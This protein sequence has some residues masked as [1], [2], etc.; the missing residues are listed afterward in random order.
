MNTFK[1]P[2]ANILIVDDRRENIHLLSHILREQGYRVRQAITAELA[3]STIRE[4]LPDLILLDVMLPDMNGYDLCKQLKADERTCEIPVLFMSVLDDT[5][6]KLKAF[7]VGGADY[8]SK[9]FEEQ[10]VLAHVKTHLALRHTQKQLE[11]KIVELKQ[12]KNA[13]RE[14]EK[15]YRDLVETINDAIYQT[16]ADGIIEYISPAITVMFGYDPKAMVGQCFTQFLYDDDIGMYKEYFDIARSGFSGTIEMQ[17]ITSSLDIKWIRFS[18]HSI[19]AKGRFIGTRG[20]ITDITKRKQVEEMLRKSEERLSSFMDSA[21]DGFILFDSELNYIKINSA[22]LEMT[23]LDREDVIG[24]NI[25]DIVPNLKE[26]GRYDKYKNVIETGEPFFISNLMPHP[27]FGL[28]H[29]EIKAFKISGGLGYIFTDITE[30]K[31]AEEA[32]RESEQRLRS[33]GDNL[34]SVQ[35]YQLMV[36]PDGTIRFTYVS[37]AVEK[38][39]ECTAE[40]VIADASLLYDRVVEEDR[41]GMRLASEKS[42]R[43]MDV[44]DQE[45]RIRRKSGEIRWHRMTSRPR[46]TTGNVILF[47]GIDMDIT[48]RKKTEIAVLEQKESYERLTDNADEAL[49]RVK[50]DGGE[51]IF[52]NPATERIFGYSLKEW[53]A[54]KAHAFKIIHPDFMEKQQRVIEKINTTK[55]PFKDVELGWIAKD[56]RTIFMEHTIIPVLDKEG[57]IIYFEALGRDITERKQAKQVLIES[58]VKHRTLFE[59]MSQ[60]VVYQ[61]ADGHIISANSSAENILG[62]SLEQMTGRTSLDPRWRAIHEDGSEFPGKTHPGHVAMRTGKSVHNEIMGVFHPK[63]NRYKWISIDA[64]PQF[65]KGN[66]KPYQVYAT[67]TDITER[68]QAEE[69][70]CKLNKELEQKV[71][72]RTHDLGQRVK[73]LN[74]LYSISK[75]VETPDASLEE[76]LQGTVNLISPF[77]QYSDITCAR[78]IIEG[79]MF[80]TDNFKE[81]IW[82][83]A[84]DILDKGE[85]IGSLDV[86]YLEERQVSDEGPFLKEERNMIDAITE[87][88][89][90]VVER[91]YAEEALLKSEKRLR[92]MIENS[93]LPM[94]ITDANQ[95]MEYFNDKFTELFG[96]TLNDVSTA[97]QWWQI[98]YPDENYRRSVQKSWMDAIEYAIAHDEDIEMQEWDLTIKDR[99]K[100]RCEFY[101]VPFEEFSLIIMNDITENI[102][103]QTELKEAKK[104][105]ETANKAKSAFLANMSHELRTPLNA[106]LGFAQLML[107]DSDLL[108]SQRKNME[109]VNRSGEHLL[110]LINDILDMSK[111]EAGRSILR[112]R[113]FDL[114]QTLTNIEEM[115]RVRAD[116]ANL[117]F[118]VFRD[119]GV[120][121]YIQGDDRKLRQV[122]INLLNNAIKF[123]EKG[124]VTLQIWGSGFKIHF[125][126]E[127]TGV[128]IASSDLKAVFDVFKR[129]QSGLRNDEGTGLGLAISRKL[130]RL[131]GGD[132]TVASEVG[133]GS[134]FTFHI[135]AEPADAAEIEVEPSV[136]KVIGLEPNQET[137]LILIVEDKWE[138]RKFLAQLLQSA[139]F[140]VQEA[141]NGQE[142]IEMIAKERPHLIFMDM[143]MPVKD[144]FEATRII[145]ATPQGQK[146]PVIAMTASVFEEERTAILAAGCD[147]FICKPA[148]ESEIFEAVK[149]HLRVRYIYEEPA[150]QDDVRKARTDLTLADLDCLPAEW[151]AEFRQAVKRG[152]RKPVLKLIEQIRPEKPD[153]AEALVKLTRD[154]RFDKLIALTSSP[155]KQYR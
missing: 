34:P 146:I 150:E 10:E 86:Y 65:K 96:Y 140:A 12:T 108:P 57:K 129:T 92:T 88:L 139:G 81:T 62:V 11:R 111:I 76:I 50:A 105:A 47:D 119:N 100:R 46:L 17:I 55:R 42:I 31:R 143:R 126:I 121:Q 74:C 102:N 28:K 8:L 66:K 104:A 151:I 72:Q 23:G 149:R 61:N 84:S 1:Q 130:V 153:I 25:L 68:K 48:E 85:P 6:D 109:I 22:A 36:R 97:E 51:V 7:D 127:D 141:V 75:L 133:K 20:V 116:A 5:K 14:S 64:I 24:K 54:D 70:I 90:K 60:G 148:H 125:K 128:G 56:G 118:N 138:N 35:I 19:L 63:A 134:V 82:K 123:T 110:M 13:L 73:E 26:T 112:N 113:N 137:Y 80:Q 131:M 154:F 44:F 142:A 115:I 117:K 43:E 38:L 33:I 124:S 4:K 45:I 147:E 145:K 30:R 122:L 9:P 132:I 152:Y 29:I 98:A 94:V 120:P 18:Y 3:L 103:I 67:F 144:G 136:R 135:P 53:L 95:D 69:A 37:S 59:S 15:I 87:R 93:P 71:I 41:E 155:A 114:F 79:R 101:M 58:E 27:K 77:W 21:T 49:V 83:L 89:G 16:D 107:R 2:V 40:Q 32:L 106:I 91:K 52:V 99:T 78:I 39:H